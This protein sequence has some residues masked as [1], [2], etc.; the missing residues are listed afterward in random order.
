[1]DI[2]KHIEEINTSGISA[3]SSVHGLE[4][5]ELLKFSDSVVLAYGNIYSANRAFIADVELLPFSKDEIRAALKIQFYMFAY[6]KD[7]ASMEGIARAYI[8]L[9]RFQLILD[10]DKSALKELDNAAVPK[11]DLFECKTPDLPMNESEQMFLFRFATFNS[12]LAKIEQEKDI[13]RADFADFISFM[14]S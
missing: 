1:M 14:R 8:G 5:L 2:Q 12:Y 13:L 6:K 9:S 4:K 3:I 11:T 10:N 7:A